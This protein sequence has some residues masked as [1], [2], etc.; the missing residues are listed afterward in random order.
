MST[1][2]DVAKRARA[3]AA[4][5]GIR[6][7]MSRLN[8]AIAV[9]CF[10]KTYAAVLAA[11]GAGKLPAVPAVPPHITK[12]ARKYHINSHAFGQALH[13]AMEPPATDG[14]RG[15]LD[16]VDWLAARY[17]P[18]L[19]EMAASELFGLADEP[20]MHALFAN[21]RKAMWHR[22]FADWLIAEGTLWVDGKLCRSIELLRQGYTNTLSPH[23][24]LYLEAL[25]TTPL[26]LY[27]VESVVPGYSLQLRQIGAVDGRVVTVRERSGSDPSMQGETIGA[28]LVPVGD[29]HE[30]AGGILPFTRVVGHKVTS[31]VRSLTTAAEISHAI[32]CA[33]LEHFDARQ[34]ARPNFVSKEGDPLLL[35]TDTYH[36]TD[37]ALLEQ[38][39]AADSRFHGSPQGGWSLQEVTDD[40]RVRQM[41]GLHVAEGTENQITAFYETEQRAAR[42][43]PVVEAVLGDL[44][45]HVERTS[46]DVM[47]AVMSE[48]PDAGNNQPEIPPDLMTA[49]VES[50]T[51]EHY[52]HW[53]DEP[54]P[55]LDHQTP[56]QALRTHEGESRVRELL[57]M[58][59][60][61]E[62]NLAEQAQR[63][64]IS[65][66]FLYAAL[67]LAAPTSP[68]LDP[69]SSDV[70]Q[71]FN[72]QVNEAWVAFRVME[73]PVPTTDAGE[74]N[75]I[76]LMDAGSECI[77]SYSPER[78]G[79]AMTQ[80]EARRLLTQFPF[81]A[82]PPPRPARTLYV[83][84]T[85]EAPALLAEAARLG[86][87]LIP[88]HED[89]LLPI[90][91]EARAGMG[92]HF[93]SVLA[94]R[95]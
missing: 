67:G 54:I 19:D 47:E 6:T 69:S 32:R 94:P 45:R 16:A 41:C 21:E 33:W 78:V 2:R 60:S 84:T 91:G 48:R 71:P 86:M 82:P 65:Y 51:R 8:D 14:G 31:V 87:R 70:L 74:V 3:A 83:P 93:A 57:A 72:F 75:V 17:R 61:N 64:P 9:A 34:Q 42:F 23:N 95:D 76:A 15:V 73:E 10:G 7:P 38:R 13:N 22:A 30:M 18:Q 29:H 53:A 44:I 63:D 37:V 77:L 12:A 5:L 58:Y 24:E 46:Q 40:G 59:Q 49:L 56:R 28:R 80:L 20:V 90:I 81:V 85:L 4:D 43:R 79:M 1:F 27:L 88:V 92:A 55:Y 36:C 62:L 68:P 50:A 66:D 26:R 39:L 25:S 35:I 52:A 11:E 89:A